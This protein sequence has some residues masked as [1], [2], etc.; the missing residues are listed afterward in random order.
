[1][2]VKWSILVGKPQKR[3]VQKPVV[4]VQMGEFYDVFTAIMS[5]LLSFAIC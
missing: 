2:A 4:V 3:Y 5:D 1:M